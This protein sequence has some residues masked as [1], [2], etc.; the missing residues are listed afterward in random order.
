MNAP[1]KDCKDR[2][3][4]CHST[5]EKYKKFDEENRKRREEEFK[6]RHNKKYSQWW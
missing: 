1:C 5:C 4:G 3:L 2:K 6:N